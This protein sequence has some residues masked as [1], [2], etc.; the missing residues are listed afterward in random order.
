MQYDWPGNVRELENVMKSLTIMTRSSVIDVE[1]LPRSIV[2][3]PTGTDVGEA[4][5]HSVL[6]M[7]QP[8]IREYVD[9]GR[10]GLLHEMTAHLE[11]PLIRQVL[12][13][14]RWNP[15][16]TSDILGI[17]RNPLRTRRTSNRLLVI[18]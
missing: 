16:K 17:N 5:E 1:D 6:Q 11:R 7:W 10:S 9:Q 18:T 2:G 14:T 3:M 15:V 4:F 8:L 12:M 13:Q